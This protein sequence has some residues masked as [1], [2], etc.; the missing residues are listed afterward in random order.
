MHAA[1]YMGQDALGIQVLDQW[2]S[3]GKV[4]ARTIKWTPTTSGP[5]QRR[6]AFSVVVW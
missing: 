3:K 4:T 1:I 5:E 2:K 6:N